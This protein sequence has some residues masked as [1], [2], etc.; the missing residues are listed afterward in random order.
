LWILCPQS[1]ERPETKG[2]N[3]I[4]QIKSKGVQKGRKR[5]LHLGLKELRKGEP[6]GGSGGGDIKGKE[7]KQS[8]KKRTKKTVAFPFEG[9]EKSK[10][11]YL[12]R[13]RSAATTTSTHKKGPRDFFFHAGKVQC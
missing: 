4:E 11:A 10:T 12:A 5:S 7:K 1:G 2:F 9:E 3:W 6:E 13:D 8:G